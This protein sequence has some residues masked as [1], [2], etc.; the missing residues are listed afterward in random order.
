MGGSA[1]RA[2]RA[3]AP[4]QVKKEGLDVIFRQK[5]SNWA[6]KDYKKLELEVTGI[7]GV[8]SLD[9]TT[10]CWHISF[11]KYY[12][13]RPL[14]IESTGTIFISFFL[15]FL[16]V[17]LVKFPDF[18]KFSKKDKISSP[19][20]FWQALVT[21]NGEID[22][23]ELHINVLEGQ[24]GADQAKYQRKRPEPSYPTEEELSKKIDQKNTTKE[25]LAWKFLLHFVFLQH[26]EK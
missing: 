23:Y 26:K 16:Q 15:C 12:H 5:N 17:E 3:V 25:W 8:L 9:L 6:Q 1:S 13:G 2:A 7:V 20:F 19:S 11:Q 18:C 24:V 22:E 10:F 21:K 4:P 14:Q